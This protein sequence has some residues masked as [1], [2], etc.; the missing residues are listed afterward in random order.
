MTPSN[1]KPGEGHTPTPWAV[2]SSTVI[3]ATE[4]KRDMAIICN[5]MDLM[6]ISFIGIKE[7]RANAAFIVEAVNAHARLLA[8]NEEMREICA[9]FIAK[10][11]RGESRSVRTYAR[12]KAALARH[13]EKEGV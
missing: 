13:P 3:V 10:C 2:S 7:S 4:D 8:S 1:P 6:G 5:T 11:D 12:M 9:D